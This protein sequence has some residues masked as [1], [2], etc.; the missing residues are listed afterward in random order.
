MSAI[1]FGACGKSTKLATPQLGYDGSAIV[2]NGVAKAEYYIFSING[3][4]ERR[5][6]NTSFTYNGNGL[7]FSVKV[8]AGSSA[9]KVNDSETSERTFRPLGTVSQINVDAQGMVSWDAVAG[10]TG[11][12]VM[13]NNNILTDV[14]SAPQYQM[15]AG[16]NTICVRGIVASDPSYYSVWSASKSITI[17][18]TPTNLKYDS[19]VITWDAVPQALK[20]E[21]KINN[22]IIDQINGTSFPYASNAPELNISVRAI[23]DGTS[24]LSSGYSDVK[25]YGF[26]E[27]INNVSFQDGMLTWDTIQGVSAYKIHI[28]KNGQ[29]Q[30]IVTVYTPS[31]SNSQVLVAN[32]TLLIRVLAVPQ[33][34]NKFSNWSQTI[35]VKL[36]SAPTNFAVSTNQNNVLLN[37]QPFT[38]EGSIIAGYTVIVECDQVTVPNKSFQTTSLN[39]SFDENDDAFKTAGVYSVFV[40]ARAIEGDAGFAYGD[41]LRTAP[42]TVTRLAQVT[43]LKSRQADVN[44]VQDPEI[45]WGAVAAAGSTTNYKLSVSR[46]G[47]NTVFTKTGTTHAY[48][49]LNTDGAAEDATFSVV[50]TATNANGKVYLDS[51]PS[52]EMIITKLATPSKPV[53]ANHMATWSGVAN[54]VKYNMTVGVGTPLTTTATTGSTAFSGLT[55]GNYDLVVIAIGDGTRYITSN[56]SEAAPISKLGAPRN[57]VL[58]VNGLLSWDA[59]AGAV[60]YTL[61]N[62][63]TVSNLTSNN[64][65]MQD[66]EYQTGGT[67]INI[68]ALGNGSTTITSDASN[69][70]TLFK[71]GTPNQPSATSDTI[72]WNSIPQANQYVV[73]KNGS[74]LANVTGLNATSFSTTHLDVGNNQI[75][76]QA[77]RVPHVVN[78]TTFYANS[79]EVSADFNKLAAPVVTINASEGKYEWSVILGASGYEL[80]LDS[81]QASIPNQQTTSYTL[82]KTLTAKTYAVKIRAL[83]TSTGYVN[84]NWTTFNQVVTP[85]TQ[86]EIES[87][88]LDAQRRVV[89][90]ARDNSVGGLTTGY[91]FNVGGTNK[92]EQTG[93]TYTGDIVT[94]AGRID[95]YVT[96]VGGVFGA[97]DTGTAVFYVNSNASVTKNITIYETLSQS[98]LVLSNDGDGNRTVR[99]NTNGLTSIGNLFDIVIKI[100]GTEISQY[101]AGGSPVDN[102]NYVNTQSPIQFNATAGQSVE[103]IVVSKGN[104]TTTFD[105][106]AYTYTFTAQ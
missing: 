19:E 83:N 62:G 48:Q 57:F 33:D 8:R 2:W 39:M 14:I 26:L 56:E 15:P 13:L 38:N 52:T 106:N 72:S 102:H 98:N 51:V 16:T 7:E 47:G 94:V 18:T 79:A 92:P 74:A 87:L 95:V 4:E 70:I 59:V 35:T 49:F 27:P 69:P 37:W 85:I 73:K 97:G 103:I 68:T 10:A 11:Y 66:S 105:S 9:K 12:R 50:A 30:P 29:V 25:T 54:A 17:L 40:V 91:I 42:V 64:R 90:V 99:I 67:S 77:T 61:G 89:A 23:G 22:E 104:G 5:V 20:Y 78:E 81:T 88:T 82:S 43:G 46:S 71:L 96:A 58:S 24:R 45:S 44:K 31:Y 32:A 34:N 60:S 100:N 76:V 75:T 55:P 101:L 65:Q 53:L 36:L 63:I 86:P 80:Y 84:S 93:K 28:T 1:V 3:G 41:S 21:L 6:G